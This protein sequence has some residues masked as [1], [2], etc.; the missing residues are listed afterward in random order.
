M[1]SIKIQLSK[2]LYI[3]LYHDAYIVFDNVN[4]FMQ[5]CDYYFKIQVWIETYRNNI[6]QVDGEFFGGRLVKTPLELRVSGK[7]PD[8]LRER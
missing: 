3:L 1:T 4:I 5:L 6:K 8:V 7:C 2:L